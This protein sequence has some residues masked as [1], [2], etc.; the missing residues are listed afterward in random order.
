VQALF[1]LGFFLGGFDIVFLFFSPKMV[2]K[3]KMV[4]KMTERARLKDIAL[5]T[6]N[7]TQYLIWHAGIIQTMYR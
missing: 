2:R 5:L 3:I 6:H 1:V 4:R 7:K